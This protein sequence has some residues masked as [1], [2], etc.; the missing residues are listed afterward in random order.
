ME[1]T[2]D[3]STIKATA[4]ALKKQIRAHL[5][6]TARPHS[7][8]S[9]EA[10]GAIIDLIEDAMGVFEEF[11]HTFSPIERMRMNGMGMKNLGFAHTA[12]AN[13]RRNPTFVPAYL[14][15]EAWTEAISDFE[16]KRDILGV[17]RQLNQQVQDG[18]RVPAD[19]A[20]GFALEYYA[21]IKEAAKRKVAGAQSEY[22][23][24]S[25]FFKNRG[26]WRAQS[27][28]TAAEVERDVHALLH[29]KKDGEVI[30][31]NE[32]PHLVGGVRKVADEVAGGRRPPA[33]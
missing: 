31:R 28:P 27:E 6:V 29:G 4:S 9:P 7:A 15:M 33:T 17:I 30:V 16:A 12:Y 13:A 23:E 24:L 10:K 1:S 8:I 19:A 2:N 25:P 22:A 11:G 14:D 32:R 20:Y 26:H 3:L 5:K 18:L 21:S